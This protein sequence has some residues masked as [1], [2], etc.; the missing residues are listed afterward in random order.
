[1]HNNTGKKLRRES[2]HPS[3]AA[4][5]TPR[6]DAIPYQQ[7]NHDQIG[8][9]TMIPFAP[10]S[11]PYSSAFASGGG[12]G[13][14]GADDDDDFPRRDER[15][16]QWGDQ[17]TRVL[18]GIGAQLELEFT[19]AE[20]D[21]ELWEIVAYSMEEKGYSRTADQCN[22]KWNNLVSSY[23][24]PET[25]VVECPF[26]NELHAV[27][28]A[29]ANRMQPPQPDTD[30]LNTES[31]NTNTNAYEDQPHELFSHGQDEDSDKEIEV[32][33]VAKRT[34]LKRKKSVREKRQKTGEVEIYTNVNVV[35]NLREIMRSFMKQQQRMDARWRKSMERRAEERDSFENEW[36]RKMERLERHRVT[37][38]KDRRER[39]EQRWSRYESR[40][41]KGDALLTKLVKKLIP[42]ES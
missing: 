37:M 35:S 32:E 19:T 3:T 29:R 13:T 34:A 18:I 21:K 40:A 36:W 17:E 7:L 11:L 30:T 2:H 25:S 22:L 33:Q 4:A 27:F 41:E 14:G 20:L 15:S 31:R 5:T 28:T 10:S 24:G 9:P 39:E 1:M 8:H 12:V 26:F 16:L 6:T 42:D 23:K 38:E